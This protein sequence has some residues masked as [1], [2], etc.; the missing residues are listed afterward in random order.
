MLGKC[1]K[2]AFLKCMDWMV[3]RNILI[4]L[5]KLCQLH[6]SRCNT[7]YENRCIHMYNTFA[8]ML[9]SHL[10][11]QLG[12]PRSESAPS[13]RKKMTLS[14][15]SSLWWFS[16]HQHVTMLS[17]IVGKQKAGSKPLRSQE[18]SHLSKHYFVALYI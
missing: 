4:S 9:N 12:V 15:T 11:F 16:H 6:I 3:T 18:E 14:L 1:T 17:N 13:S 2:G 8:L 5:T 7:R 10:W